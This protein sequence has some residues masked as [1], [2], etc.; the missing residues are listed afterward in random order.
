MRRHSQDFIGNMDVNDC[1][2]LMDVPNIR[3][4]HM[5]NSSIP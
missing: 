3:A 1:N 4:L 5:T 2:S